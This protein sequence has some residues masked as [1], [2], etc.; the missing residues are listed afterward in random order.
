VKER[1]LGSS[2]Q[3]INEWCYDDISDFITSSLPRTLKSIGSEAAAASILKDSLRSV[4]RLA[5]D[6]SAV[7]KQRTLLQSLECLNHILA[8]DSDNKHS[9]LACR[10]DYEIFTLYDSFYGLHLLISGF[11]SLPNIIQLYSLVGVL[12]MWPILFLSFLTV[13][14]YVLHTLMETLCEKISGGR[15]SKMPHFSMC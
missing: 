10:Q 3:C 5:C 14:N 7:M 6:G 11:F 8:V 15:H 2:L 4:S 12:M 13:G 1:V 9:F